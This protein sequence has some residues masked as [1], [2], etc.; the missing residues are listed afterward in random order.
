MT[1]RPQKQRSTKPAHDES[2][3]ISHLALK[4]KCMI[5]AINLVVNV[6]IIF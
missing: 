6:Y 2:V 5:K 4:C 3:T 1:T